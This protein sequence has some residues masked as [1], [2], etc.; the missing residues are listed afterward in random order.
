[1]EFIVT[2]LSPNLKVG[3]EDPK[4][5]EQQGR[6]FWNGEP[7]NTLHLSSFPFNPTSTCQFIKIVSQIL[8]HNIYLESMTSPQSFDKD[9]SWYI[10]DKIENVG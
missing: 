2:I 1:M 7:V 3:G 8:F 10:T 9:I 4:C 6:S 5:L